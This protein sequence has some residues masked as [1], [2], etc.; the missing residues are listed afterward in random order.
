MTVGTIKLTREAVNSLRALSHRLS[1]E[2][3]GPRVTL[4]D[5]VLV[6][7]RIGREAMRDG[8]NLLRELPGRESPSTPVL[9]PGAETATAT[10]G[11][12][13]SCAGTVAP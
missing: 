6:L 5:T 8:R 7:C 10:D 13:A 4:S 9:E 11:K 2:K 1:A 3:G 12:H